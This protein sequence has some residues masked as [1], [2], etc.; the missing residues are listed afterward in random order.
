MIDKN[1]ESEAAL[2]SVIQSRPWGSQVTDKKRI[3]T[4]QGMNLDVR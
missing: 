1:W 4:A 3:K 2:S